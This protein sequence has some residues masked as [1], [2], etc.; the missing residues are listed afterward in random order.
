M[1]LIIVQSQLKTA[2]FIYTKQQ[3]ISIAQR[4]KGS[5]TVSINLILFAC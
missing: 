1:Q 4:G 3:Q 5:V 2:L